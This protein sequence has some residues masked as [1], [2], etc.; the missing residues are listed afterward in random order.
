MLNLYYQDIQDD[1]V[2]TDCWTSP[3]LDLINIV[4]KYILF[5]IF[6]V[7]SLNE[8]SEG[9]SSTSLL[10]HNKWDNYYRYCL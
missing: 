7:I 5:L 4:G 8:I 2:I 1:Y 9:T 10:M 6:D 3:L